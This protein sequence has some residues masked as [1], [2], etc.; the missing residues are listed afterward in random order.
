MDPDYTTLHRRTNASQKSKKYKRLRA[1]R[2]VKTIH[3]LDLTEDDEFD[4]LKMTLRQLG[5]L[6]KFRKNENVKGRKITP[7]ASRK[8][9]W[10]FWHDKSHPSTITSRPAK[11]KVSERNKI[12]EGLDFVDTVTSISQG[13]RYFFLSHWFITAEPLKPLYAEYKNK[14]PEFPV[15]YGTYL[16]LRPF[17]VRSVT[18]KDI[19]MCCCKQHLHARWAIQ[20]LINNAEKQGIPL[21]FTNYE[22]FFENFT[23]ECKDNQSTYIKWEFTPSK[24]VICKT[25]VNLW[26]AFKDDMVT[27]DDG[28][29]YVS[30]QYFEVAVTKKDGLVTKH[31]NQSINHHLF[32]KSPE[33]MVLYV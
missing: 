1:N 14:Y 19:E 23:S 4:M 27:K 32:N 31:L 12:Q 2:L 13:K 26:E 33:Y 16:S 5:H 7:L 25:I 10:K 15:S 8:A 29:T 9:V 18:A 20:A 22:S 17:Y 24:H 3:A 11:L 21:P 30:M 28:V 6:H